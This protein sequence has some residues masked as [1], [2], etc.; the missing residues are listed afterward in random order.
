MARKDLPAWQQVV[1]TALNNVPEAEDGHD[2]WQKLNAEEQAAVMGFLGE[3]C[4]H[5]SEQ[6]KAMLAETAGMVKSRSEK[7]LITF[8]VV[9]AVIV[10]SLAMITILEQYFENVTR[11]L[12]MF[13]WFMFSISAIINAKRDRMMRLWS[14]RKE[15]AESIR[16]ALE[17]MY[18]TQTGTVWAAVRKW[19]LFACLLLLVLWSVSLFSELT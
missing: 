17:S 6:A 11:A 15:N 1:L 14:Q 10:A 18:Q 8:G 9:L 13:T 2:A 19:W 4:G 16:A 5:A 3:H 12:H 7:W